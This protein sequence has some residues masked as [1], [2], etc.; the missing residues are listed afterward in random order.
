MKKVSDFDLSKVFVEDVT[1]RIGIHVL[2]STVRGATKE[3]IKRSLRLHKKGVCDHKVVEDSYGW[4][5]DFRSCAIC[6]KGLGTV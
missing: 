2:A 3:D 6:G 4:M 1:E 5:Y